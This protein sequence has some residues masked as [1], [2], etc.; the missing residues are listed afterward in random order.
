MKSKKIYLILI[1]QSQ[2]LLTGKYVFLYSENI[3]LNIVFTYTIKGNWNEHN[4]TILYS[5][6]FYRGFV[7]KKVLITQNNLYS[8]LQD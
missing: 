8:I 5:R 1:E 4:F 3:I 7:S 2:K 6:H